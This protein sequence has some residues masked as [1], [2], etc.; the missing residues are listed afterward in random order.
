MD[1]TCKYV[2][3]TIFDQVLLPL[4]ARFADLNASIYENFKK[5]IIDIGPIGTIIYC[6]AY[7]KAYLEILR[8]I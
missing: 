1:Y 7:Q 2:R 5:S 4:L 6:L 8:A 3:T